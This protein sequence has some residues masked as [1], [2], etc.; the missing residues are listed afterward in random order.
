MAPDE[1]NAQCRQLSA[2]VLPSGGVTETELLEEIAQ[3]SDADK[4]SAPMF[5]RIFLVNVRHI[6]IL[7]PGDCSGR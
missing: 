4:A 1:C 7:M 3:L 2:M 6:T 5:L